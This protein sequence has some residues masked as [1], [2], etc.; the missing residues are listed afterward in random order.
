MPT[1]K[2][3]KEPGYTLDLLLLYAT[4]FNKKHFIAD[5]RDAAYFNDLCAQFA[6]FD[7][8]LLVFFHKKEGHLC[9]I[10]QFAE[11][12]CDAKWISPD[13]FDMLQSVLKD[14]TKVLKALMAFYFPDTGDT[15]FLDENRFVEK[16]GALI[17]ESNYPSA[18]KCSLYSLILDP[19]YMIQKLSYSLME[20]RL[21]LSSVYEKSLDQLLTLQ[22]EFDLETV[23]RFYQSNENHKIDTSFYDEIYVSFI[24]CRKDYVQTYSEGKKWLLV[25]G[26]DY[27]SKLKEALAGNISVELDVFG[28]ALA[29]KN[30]L[31][32]LDYILEKGETTIGEIEQV[33]GLTGTN[34]YY[35][36]SLLL[37]TDL[38]RARKLG[39]VVYY[40]INKK[41]FE[42]VSNALKRYY[43]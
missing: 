16:A 26:S 42:Q 32:I 24:L 39:R 1:V 4:Y 18:L 6:P 21:Q 14:H 30:R 29:E 12:E 33:F 13:L 35:H 7:D 2:F 34:A 3:C 31:K 25:L 20:K 36:L 37:K 8:D 27:V 10:K 19:V 11:R 28:N 15:C 40:S 22:Q 38:I 17:R 23:S 41:R 5:S 43:V 9:F